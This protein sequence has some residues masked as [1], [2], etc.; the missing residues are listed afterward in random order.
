MITHEKLVEVLVKPGEQILREMTADDAHLTHMIMGVCG[1]SGELL[2]AIKKKTIYQKDLDI[3][4]IIEEL[5]DIEFYLEGIRQL[6]KISR[7]QCLAHNI[8]KLSKRYEGLKYSNEA[9]QAR[10]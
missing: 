10:K 2:D 5:G 7:K 3:E 6:L 8:S 1:E 4:N 9:A